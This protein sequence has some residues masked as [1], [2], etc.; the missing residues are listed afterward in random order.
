M[1]QETPQQRSV[2]EISHLFLST[3]REKS[4]NG[5]PR[6]QRTPPGQIAPA[7]RAAAPAP[8]AT[9]G[10]EP[11][12]AHPRLVDAGLSVDLSPEEFARVFPE[13]DPLAIP[14]TEA[15]MDIAAPA[16]VESPTSIEA[17]AA[18][19][20]TIAPIAPSP[21]PAA[22]IDLDVP[23]R[24]PAV[25]A[26]LAA[27][28]G[29]GQSQAVL[30][31]ARHLTAIH[32]RVGLVELNGDSL[33]LLRLEP[34]IPEVDPELDVQE[35]IQTQ[36]VR[37]VAESLEEM[38]WDV[39]RWL[40][41]TPTPRAPEARE[42]L[43][44]IGHWVIL[45][46]CDH[47]GVVA[48]YRL[49]K[50]LAGGARPR[51]SLALIGAADDAEADRVYRKLSSVCQQFLGWALEDESMVRPSARSG[52]HLV[53]V[54]KS[55]AG[56]VQSTTAEPWWQAV[57]AFLGSIKPA[58]LE[59]S[60][61]NSP[62]TLPKVETMQET[63]YAGPAPVEL[64]DAPAGPRLAAPAPVRQ[65]PSSGPR[66]T[67][68]PAPEAA[69]M[70]TMA[71]R[72]AGE[73]SSVDVLEVDAAGGAEAILAA[74]LQQ[75]QGE[76][77]ASPIRPP[78]CTSA[79][80]AITRDRKMMLLAVAR[81]GLAE[82]RAIGQAYRWVCENRALIS[83]AMPQFAIDITSTPRIRLLVDHADT[84]AGVLQPI[85]QSEHVSVQAYRKLRWGGKTGLFLEAA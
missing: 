16:A 58:E 27:H 84:S 59:P 8:T 41:L 64:S 68:T 49:L 54:C 50:G 34:T 62:L 15:P 3:V 36:S 77:V 7:A 22:S 53:L 25:C 24:T 32:G 82:L 78:M 79:R 35:A 67:Y 60:P 40:V 38:N 75:N 42:L 66:M 76:L 46:T 43:G 10:V 73:D 81:E 14:A 56:K 19:I 20:A 47:D 2:S 69:A 74:I 28:L 12:R 44:K 26:V 65:P 48:S 9:A 55:E 13:T 71:L 63:S 29:N 39:E 85:L 6:P 70:P 52:E 51:L 57:E 4:G 61:G 1:L 45:S 21:A 23:R 83:M 18:P 5:S 72:P 17:P 31:Y 80:L 33:R 30:E 11:Q 37:D